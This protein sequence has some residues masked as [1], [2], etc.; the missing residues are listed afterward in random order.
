MRKMP[1]AV[2]LGPEIVPPPLSRTLRVDELKEGEGWTI[3]VYREERETIAALLDLAALDR[4][5]FAFSLH[6][7]GQGR[8]ALRGNLSAAVTQTCVVSLEPVES[9]LDVPVEAEF[10]PAPMI[11]DLASSPD[12]A[13]SHGML[14]WP[15][16]IEG[17]KI[18]LGPVIY[19]TLATALDPY[20]KRE[21]ASLEWSEAGGDALPEQAES[22]FAALK[23]LK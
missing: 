20:P 18:D 11:D 23:R 15:E 12:E 22:P 2:E 7:R 4:L 8:L 14:D 17:G 19:E 13:A 21:G 1:K 5:S 6:R 16:P 10:W 3:E 9:A